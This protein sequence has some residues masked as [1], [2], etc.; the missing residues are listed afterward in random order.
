MRS[1]K[2]KDSDLTIFRAIFALEVGGGEI[3]IKAKNKQGAWEI[4]KKIEPKAWLM[5][6]SFEEIGCC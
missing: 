4:L 6:K 3:E 1:E 2:R 5:I